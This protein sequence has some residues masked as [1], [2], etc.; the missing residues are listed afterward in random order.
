MAE[1]AVPG[2]EPDWERAPEHQG[3]KRNPALQA[4]MWEY[5]AGAFRLVAGLSP[6]LEVLAARLR[7]DIERGWEDLGPVD[8]AMFRIQKID[9][10]LS[11]L[12]G[13]PSPDVLVWVGRAVADTDAALDILLNALGIGEAA[14][15][16]RGDTETGFTDL[17]NNVEA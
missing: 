3:G 10:A 6:S 12:E 4:S 17:R 2:P 8:V 15:T 16:F 5:A 1:L 13:S 11:R 7:L 9:F 14:L